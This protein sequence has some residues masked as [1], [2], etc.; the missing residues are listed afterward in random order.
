MRVGLTKSIKHAPRSE[1]TRVDE[2]ATDGD[3]DFNTEGEA[4]TFAIW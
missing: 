4:S 3:V 2:K 1:P